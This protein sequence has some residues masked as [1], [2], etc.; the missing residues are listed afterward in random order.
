MR[1]VDGFSIGSVDGQIGDLIRRCPGIISEYRFAY[2]TSI[3]S[4]TVL[5]SDLY[6]SIM[7]KYSRSFC[8]IGYGLQIFVAD[9]FS[10]SVDLKLFSGFDE[11]WF[12]DQTVTIPKPLDFWIVGPTDL[13][14]E[15]IP[16]SLFTWMWESNCKLGLG[17]GTGLNYITPVKG[18][19][20][21]ITSL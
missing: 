14:L 16:S 21:E 7:R 17:D 1:Q 13:E 2:I 15:N 9:L 19:A 5:S 10:I 8:Q 3:D 18:K 11:I 6:T 4:D 20:L 12:F